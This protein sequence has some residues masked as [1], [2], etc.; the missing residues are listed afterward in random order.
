MINRLV[1]PLIILI[2]ILTLLCSS[3]VG[4]DSRKASEDEIKL[5][6]TIEQFFT[7]WLVKR[8]PEA[9][10]K[11]VSSKAILCKNVIP[12]EFK[13]KDKLS[14][15]D[16]NHI[17][18]QVFT[19]TL[20]HSQPSDKLANSISSSKDFAVDTDNTISIEHPNRKLF[21]LFLLNITKGKTAQDFGFICKFDESPSFRQAV[22]QPTSYYVM[23]KIQF[24]PDI[25][26]E[27]YPDNKFPFE[28][29]WVK[30][31]NDWHILTF[32]SIED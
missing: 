22:G 8:D 26:S 29:V 15:E 4:A 2:S 21:E 1:K 25:I 12:D 24:L 3:I 6:R 28:M 19:L 20:K 30:E 5:T 13:S 27:A 32:A 16:I 31:G 7:D 18:K 14:Q 9:A 17:F 10:I 11:Y 23:T